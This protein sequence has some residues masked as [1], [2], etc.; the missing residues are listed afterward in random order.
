MSANI[1]QQEEP[2]VELGAPRNQIKLDD[3]NF[4]VSIENGVKVYR[5]KS[6]SVATPS[7]SKSAAD[8]IVRVSQN[9]QPP[10]QNAQNNLRANGY[11][12]SIKQLSYPAEHRTNYYSTDTYQTKP[13]IGNAVSSQ[14]NTPEQSRI[15]YLNEYLQDGIYIDAPPRINRFNANTNS[16]SLGKA[17]FN[18]AYSLESGSQHLRQQLTVNVLCFFDEH[19]LHSS[20][21]DRLRSSVRILKYH[22]ERSLMQKAV[23]CRK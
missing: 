8:R 4:D 21:T 15:H 17:N 18:N 13:L 12:P 3:V 6:R 19:Q 14:Y 2:I 11:G 23:E 9:Y 7:Y 20:L 1:Y 22:D 5:R 16:Y 10:Y